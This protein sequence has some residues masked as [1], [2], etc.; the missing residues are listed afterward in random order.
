[1]SPASRSIPGTCPFEGAVAEFLRYLRV[2]AGLAP[3]TREAYRRDLADL[4]ADLR[5]YTLPGP[6]AVRAEHLAAHLRDLYRVRNLQPVSIA[7]HLAT[8]RVFFRFLTAREEVP[9]DPTRPL[10]S[11]TR[12]KRLPGVL[13]PRR[14]KSL[15][16]APRPGTGELWLRDRA[17][18][19]LMYASGLRAS[20]VGRVALD[21]YNQTLGVVV[22]TGKGGRQRL[23]PV[24]RPARQW[25][26]RYLRELRP[27]LTR[28]GD[29]RDRGRL[30]LS[31]TGRPLERVAVWQI[32]RRNAILAGLRD[33]HPHVLRHSFATHLL[34]GG[35]DLR[36]VQELLGHANIATTQIYTH[37]DRSRLRDV[38][39]RHHPRP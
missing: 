39:R 18:L 21:E 14:M 38:I 1:M 34:A 8:L 5:A 20:E 12:W 13:S 22:V 35:A 11:P 25:L 30:L 17:L 6:K 4:V 15:L 32:V 33:V 26:K 10:E 9:D 3:A 29:G 31:H 7:R 23:V 36:T 24:G 27:H 2:E 19:E 16:E 37:V 28:F